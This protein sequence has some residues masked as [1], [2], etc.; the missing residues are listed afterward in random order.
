VKVGL[1]VL[2]GVARRPEDGWIPCLHWLIERL[3]SRHDVHVF[4]V[5]GAPRPDHYAFLGAMVHHAGARP[6]ALRTATAI[7]AEH[8]RARFDVLHA[9]WVVPPGVIARVTSAL[10]GCPVLLHVSGGELASVPDIR[11]GGLRTWAGRLWTRIGLSGASRITA[12]SAPLID[13]LGAMGYAAERVPLGVDLT[14]WPV[15]APRPRRS[16][17][18]RLV[19]VASLN[20]VKDQVTLL[21]AVRLLAG[22]GLDFVLDIAGVDTLG[23]TIQ[24]LAQRTGIGDRVRFHGVLDRV[25]LHALMA[26]ASILLVSSRHEAGPLVV[27]EAALVGV[28][29]VGTAVGHVAEWAPDAAVAVPVR[30]PEALARETFRLLQDDAR[31]VALGT[32]AQRRAL[33]YDA[34]WTARRFEALYEE[35]T[36]RRVLNA[37][38]RTGPVR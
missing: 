23:G 3:A 22:K 2:G 6:A 7:M 32:E 10:I 4:S 18:A 20:P 21:E 26:D 5:Y 28:P 8:R 11:Y 15:V 1:V 27:L 35:L 30:D 13:Q 33:P 36:E 16:G 14:S 34:D 31:R 29:T 38:R 19:H 17:P 37:A 25:R 9:F 12:A 24:A